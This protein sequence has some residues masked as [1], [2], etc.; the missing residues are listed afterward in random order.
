MQFS[1]QLLF[2][3]SALGAFNGLLLSLYLFFSKSVTQDRKWLGLLLLAISLRISKSV[4]FYFDPNLGKQFLQLGLSACFMI[5]PL[6]YFYV[7]SATNQ[8]L[9]LKI[10][11]Q[12]HIT[13]L[14][15]LMIIFGVLFPYQS[16]LELWQ[17][18][19][20]QFINYFWAGY[21]VLTAFLLMPMAMVWVGDNSKLTSKDSLAVKVFAGT[22]VIWLAFFT[23]SY[24][25]Y[26]LGALSFS[27]V[28]YLTIV[29]WLLD[30]KGKTGKPYVAKT[31]EQTTALEL[32][33]KLE[34]LMKTEQL[35][36]NA[37]LTL[38]VLAKKLGVSVP[39]LSQ[40]LNDNLAKSFAQFINEYRINEAKALLDAQ[41]NM[42][43]DVVA[44]LSGYNS[45]STFYSAFKQFTNTTPAKYRS[46]IN[47]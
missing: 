17:D 42:T 40:F 22:T 10:K 6:L 7:A 39:V 23:A 18:E 44:E 19:V 43:V 36:K 33:I 20:Y 1:S 37:N 12:W 3:F 21:L 31:I 15:C 45:Q 8:L 30:S 47:L 4:W 5:G 32:N 38:P 16:H 29:T 24:T 25:S 13:F 14:L 11:W 28:F 41:P 2:F 35:Y 26:I 9:D 46:K 27:F 34:D